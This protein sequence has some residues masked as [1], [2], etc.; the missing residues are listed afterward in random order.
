MIK[1]IRKIKME[2][3]L[4]GSGGSYM[5]AGA[6]IQDPA[7]PNRRPGSATKEIHHG[8]KEEQLDEFKRGAIKT[9][10]RVAKKLPG[11][12][13]KIQSALGLQRNKPSRYRLEEKMQSSNTKSTVI[14]T[15][16]EQDSA[17]I[18]TQ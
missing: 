16:P 8:I 3:K 10:A 15:T 6:D 13:H 14:N 11:P 17:M 4:V 9:H 5:G 18:G 12:R 7:S 2:Q 1:K